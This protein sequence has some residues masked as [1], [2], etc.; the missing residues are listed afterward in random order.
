[1][2][3]SEREDGESELERVLNLLKDGKVPGRNGIPNE[4]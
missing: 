2:R 3:G 1:M 4:V